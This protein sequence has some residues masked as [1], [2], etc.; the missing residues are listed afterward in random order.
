MGNRL[1]FIETGLP[2]PQN[3]QRRTRAPSLSPFDDDGASE[4]ETTLDPTQAQAQAISS[5]SGPPASR[6]PKWDTWPVSKK[7]T[8]A[9]LRYATLGYTGG[10]SQQQAAAAHA[11]AQAQD[12]WQDEG[13]YR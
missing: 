6:P 5:A 2:E 8:A 10:A 12:D 7:S 9:E 13:A 4:K 3:Y 1:I 11:Q